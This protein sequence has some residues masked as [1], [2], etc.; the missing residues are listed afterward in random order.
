MSLKTKYVCALCDKDIVKGK[1]VIVTLLTSSWESE[2][3]L[4]LHHK[5]LQKVC[6]RFKDLRLWKKVLH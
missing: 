4:T 6:P 1:R 5:C 2:D 3:E